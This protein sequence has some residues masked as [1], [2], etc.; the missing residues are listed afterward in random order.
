MALHQRLKPW[1]NLLLGIFCFP[2]L[3]FYLCIYCLCFR[4]S[5]KEKDLEEGNHNSGYTENAGNVPQDTSIRLSFHNKGYRNDAETRRQDNNISSSFTNKGFENDEKNGQMKRDRREEVKDDS[6]LQDRKKPKVKHSGKF[7]YL[8][9]RSNLK[10]LVIDLKDFE[11]LD[12]FAS[13]VDYK[14]TLEQFVKELI[15]VTKTDLE[16]TRAAWIWICHHIEYDVQG[17]KNR[18]AQ[19]SNA[20]DVFRTRKAVCAGYSS[21][22]QHICSL[23]GVQCKKVS[24]YS[25]GAGYQVGKIT[26]GDSDHAWNMV[27]L[28][29]RWHLLDSTWGAGTVNMKINKFNFSY[30]E[31]YFLTHPALFIEDHFPELGECQLLQTEVPL[32]IFQR[33]PHVYSDFYSLGMVSYQPQTGFIET[34]TGKVSIAFESCNDLKFTFNINEHERSG[35]LTLLDNGMKLDVY[36]QQPGQHVLNIFAQKEDAEEEELQLVIEYRI[37]CKH[38][39]SSMRIPKCIHNPVGPNR[40]T[41]KAG[42]VNP[43]HADPVIYTDDGFFTIHFMLKKKLHFF[44]TLQS[45][46]VQMTSEMENRH[47]FTTEKKNKVDINVCLPQ[48]GTYVL[49]IFIKTDN[50][51]NSKYTY[52]CNYLII[53]TNPAVGWPVFPLTYS[54]WAKHYE[55]VQPLEGIL[56]ANTDVSFKLYI[57]DAAGVCFQGQKDSPLALSDSNYWEGTCSTADRQDIIVM[58]NNNNE[59]NTWYYLIKYEVKTNKTK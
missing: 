55:L 39:D 38:I 31:F 33:S 46:E 4:K 43:S 51:D 50:N 54:N 17:Y 19:S 56:P 15:S 21:L 14:G 12:R 25:K 48:A 58:I 1:Q 26:S 49:S 37:D 16:K 44:C 59:P 10:S 52:L 53:C 42:L 23:S 35:I 57:P 7:D 9:D 8:W 34:V 40:L 27:Y 22:F 28:E 11:E 32:E 18:F 3:P 41:E 6:G 29:G 5:K 24:G 30:N 36:P 13:K 47:V 20:S 2:L 45:D